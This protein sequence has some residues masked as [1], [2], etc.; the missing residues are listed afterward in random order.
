MGPDTWQF[1][2]LVILH[3]FPILENH[4][5]PIANNFGFPIFVGNILLTKGAV[6]GTESG[7]MFLVEFTIDGR[8]FD[9]RRRC[10]GS[11]ILV[12]TRLRY[13]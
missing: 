6:M 1:E 7:T 13:P 11:S 12:K 8:Y 10:V 3:G 4:G 5:F 2:F 9:V